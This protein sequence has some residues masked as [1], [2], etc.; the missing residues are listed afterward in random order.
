MGDFHFA[1]TLPLDGTSDGPHTVVLRAIDGA[2]NVAT[3]S[4][5]FTLKTTLVNRAVTTDPAVQQMP[6]I[7]V[8][9]LDSTHLVLAYMDRSLV[10][11]GYA[12]I[13][14]A[15]S[16]DSG[17]TWQHTALP[18]PAG[19][20]QGAANPIVQFDG[21]GRVFVSFMAVTF[22]GPLA[23]ITNA[24]YDQRGLTGI[25]SNNGIFVSRSDDG[26]LT[27][28]QPV[29][30]F[31]QRYTG[32]PVSFDVTP[33]LAIDSFRTLPGGSPNPHYGEMYETWTQVYPP[34]AFPG[35]PDATG[36]TDIMVSV[37]K[38]GGQTWQLQ[39]QTLPDSGL[40]VSTIQDPVDESGQGIPLGAGFLDNAHITI[41]P[42]GDLYVANYGGGDFVVQ[43][44][45]DD[46]RSFSIPNRDTGQGL[47]FGSGGHAVSDGT[48]ITSN[49]FRNETV[50]D[51]VA[52]PTRPGTIYATEG[53]LVQDPFGNIIDTGDAVFARSTDHGQTWQTSFMV[54]PNTATNLNDD[55]HGQPAT[56]TRDDVT[57]G[58][59]L[60]RLAIDPQG[61]IAVIWYDTRHDPANHSLDVF[62]TVSTD[63]GHTFSPN[64]RITDQS[65]DANPGAFIDATGQTDYY[66]GDFLGLSVAN[67]TAYAAWAD[68]RNGSQDVYF[69]HFPLNPAPAPRTTGSPPT[70]RFKL[71]P[72]W[73]RS[74]VII[75]PSWQYRPGRT[76]GSASMPPRPET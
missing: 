15:V 35:E 65:F 23:P 32:Q 12:G 29:A 71:P 68:T 6:S 33:E 38:D 2:G 7:A 75:C 56:G 48:G 53:V 1:T 28:N 62:G 8:D 42:E 30:V 74:R 5:T 14:V 55:N 73:A 37:S 63:G 17:A 45:T 57:S 39:L 41:G 36:G 44:S 67:G 18:L 47:A 31:S 76:S 13:G 20:D 61:N 11:T 27:W 19:F 26:G 70:T 64:F 21:Q 43:H 49:Q 60:P 46:G 66:L 52:D 22:K 54:G 69:A 16:H 10:T 25:E 9:P 72:T 24:S 34:G 59:A 4:T 3:T 40:V 50:R 51:I 58:Q